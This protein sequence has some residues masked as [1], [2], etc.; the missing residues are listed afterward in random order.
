MTTISTRG[1]IRTNSRLIALYHIHLGGKRIRS[2][3][4][5]PVMSVL[6][7]FHRRKRWILVAK[8]L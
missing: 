6:G 1:T 7:L 5:E 3:W 2:C 8:A 4:C